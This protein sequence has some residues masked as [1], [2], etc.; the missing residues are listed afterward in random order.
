MSASTFQ[1]DSVKRLVHCDHLN[2]QNLNSQQMGLRK[3]EDGFYY[4]NEDCK[5]R[6]EELLTDGKIQYL[7][8]GI[9][10]ISNSNVTTLVNYLVQKNQAVHINTGTH[11]NKS[12]LNVSDTK[13]KKYADTNFLIYDLNL[14]SK[15]NNV[16]I[17]IVSTD[18]KEIRPKSANHIIDTWCYSSERPDSNHISSIY[19]GFGEGIN[20]EGICKNS[21][22]KKTNHLVIER[23]GLGVFNLHNIQYTISCPSCHK[24]LNAINN[25]WLYKCQYSIEGLKSLDSKKINVRK[26]KLNTPLNSAQKL[27]ELEG[28]WFYLNITV[29]KKP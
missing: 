10:S 16:S 29:E 17:H 22:C 19:N 15:V 26:T 25:I 9:S 27:E 1:A 5:F 8:K 24:D 12:G 14:A 7:W 2:Y 20:I 6:G 18:S 21:E 3:N 11:G 13:D 23:K 28:N 4:I